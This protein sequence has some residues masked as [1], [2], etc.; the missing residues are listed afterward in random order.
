MIASYN[1]ILTLKKMMFPYY[2]PP[3]V[4]N[5]RKNSCSFCGNYDHFAPDCNLIVFTLHQFINTEDKNDAMKLLYGKTNSGLV[6]FLNALGCYYSKE[7][8]QLTRQ[9]TLQL[10]EVRWVYFRTNLEEMIIADETIR[11]VRQLKV[12]RSIT[13]TAK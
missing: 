13:N 12:I 10:I 9:E 5:K 2:Q 7:E 6:R 8:K 4:V 1:K 3:P 11:D